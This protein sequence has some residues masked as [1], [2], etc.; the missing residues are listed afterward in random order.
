[1]RRLAWSMADT[2]FAVSRELRDFHA[3]QAGIRA[4]RI[5]VLCNGVD[6]HKFAPD[7]SSRMRIRSELGISSADF[8]VGAAG[9]IVPIKDYETLIRAVAVAAAKPLDFRLILVGDG[10]ELARL[11]ELAR[12]LPGVESRFVALGRRDD[13]PALLSAMD[14]FVQPSLREGMSNT[15]LEAMA[16][17]LPPI[18]TRVGGN[19]ELVNGDECGCLFKPGDVD[20]LSG[21]LSMLAGNRAL[22]KKIGHAARRRVQERFSDEAMLKN[23]RQLY[24]ESSSF[25]DDRT[26]VNLPC[27]GV[28][29]A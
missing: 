15:V 9:R 27:E 22:G 19:P 7:P 10:P 28:S 11:R 5:R 2:V 29:Q 21:L 3:A 24:L 23:Y 17:G 25:A 13:V 4:D 1:M 18:V 12:S 6:I 14:V 8:V 20:H 26:R 16:S